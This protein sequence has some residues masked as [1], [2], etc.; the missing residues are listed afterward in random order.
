MRRDWGRIGELQAIPTA[1]RSLASDIRCAT[2]HPEQLHRQVRCT[3]KL[4]RNN[5]PS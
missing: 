2:V 5:G 4:D 1:T 3:E